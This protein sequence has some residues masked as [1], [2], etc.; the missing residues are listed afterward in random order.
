MN[1]PDFPTTG[2]PG[3]YYALLE[4]GNTVTYKKFYYRANN[5]KGFADLEKEENI[6]C[7]KPHEDEYYIWNENDNRYHEATIE[8]WV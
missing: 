5:Q 7:I 1:K 2:R 8:Y 3:F 4:G 6:N